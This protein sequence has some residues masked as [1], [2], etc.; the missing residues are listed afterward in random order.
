MDPRDRVRIVVGTAKAV[1]DGRL[2]AA[3]AVATLRLQQEQIAPHLRGD[4][5]D[6]TAGQANEVATTLRLI[7][8]QVSELPGAAGE[9]DDLVE[10]A[11]ILGE[12]AQI[13]R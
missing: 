5:L 10:A 12:L 1:L 3:T 13:L 7:A 2:D 4:R 9:H 6:V 8:E 11:R